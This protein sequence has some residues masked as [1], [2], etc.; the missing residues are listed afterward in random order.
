MADER[1]RL[2]DLFTGFLDRPDI[3]GDV[4]IALERLI[5]DDTPFRKPQDLVPIHEAEIRCDYAR[6]IQ[7]RIKDS[8]Q[9][10]FALHAHDC[11]FIMMVPLSVLESGAL[12]KDTPAISVSAMLQ[13][14]YH[15]TGHFL[16]RPTS[17]EMVAAQST[18]LVRA[19]SRQQEGR[20]PKSRR[21]SNG[22]KASK[23]KEAA[24]EPE[25][26]QDS[27]SKEEPAE[28]SDYDPPD[29]ARSS[30]EKMKCRKRDGHTCVVM[31]SSSPELHHWWPKCYF[32]FKWLGVTPHPDIDNSSVN[33]EIQF[34][35][36]P[37]FQSRKSTVMTLGGSDSDWKTWVADMKNFQLANCQSP[38]RN[39]GASKTTTNFPIRSGHIVSINMDVS[40][41]TRFKD[42]ID[43]QWAITILGAMSGGADPPELVD[44]DDEDG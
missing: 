8:G 32:A 18:S 11:A 25:S 14:G 2:I 35:W 3:D 19:L 28:H 40:H 10:D 29:A 24:K 27:S 9:P 21:I 5:G 36:L 34:H 1:E 12:S 43:L 42:M 44:F 23:E 20:P 22:A 39:V 15:L 31:E 41:A 4:T 37:Q 30:V 16:N 7:A 13:L 6:T 26:P 38:V 17:L 33:V